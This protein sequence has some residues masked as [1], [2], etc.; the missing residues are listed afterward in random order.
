MDLIHVCLQGA[1]RREFPCAELTSEMTILLMLQENVYVF[2]LFLA[3]V[4]ERLQHVDAS[5]F[6]SHIL[7]FTYF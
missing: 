2:E 4:A 6:S 5:F 7:T 1:R 3:V